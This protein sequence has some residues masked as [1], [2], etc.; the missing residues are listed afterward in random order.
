[1][2]TIMANVHNTVSAYYSNGARVPDDA[3]SKLSASSRETW[4]SIP[5]E[6]RKLIMGTGD[7]NS[8]R[9]DTSSLTTSRNGNGRGRRTFARTRDRRK[10]A[11]TEL[12]ADDD[13][14]DTE[15][16]DGSDEVDLIDDV[17]D[18]YNVDFATLCANVAE[19]KNSDLVASGKH[20]HFRPSKR[21]PNPRVSSVPPGDVRRL[22]ADKVSSGADVKFNGVPYV[23]KMAG[24]SPAPT[25]I[26][27][28]GVTYSVKMADL[29]TYRVSSTSHSD[30]TGALVDRG[31]N[32]GIAGEDC[33]V[34]E[35]N[36]QPQRFVNVEGID[37]HVMTKRRLVTA[38]AVTETNRGPVILI[39]NQYAHSGKGHSIHSSPQL[40]WNQVDVDDKSKQ[41]GGKQRL[42]TLDGLAC[43]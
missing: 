11:F 8:S 31:A 36:D 24:S 10:V 26:D 20:V 39:M 1:M 21:T 2:D 29:T 22:L 27:F 18:Q 13:T 43:P 16:T 30:M 23:A 5:T 15:P 4:Q 3:W 33:R 6:D 14:F 42:L 17:L 38:G 19:R 25:D 7:S 41:V 40:E 12:H 9:T 34:I 32:G 35:V 37:G 28:E